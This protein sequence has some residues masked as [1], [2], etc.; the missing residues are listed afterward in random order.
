MFLMLEE[1][2]SGITEHWKLL[3][4]PLLVLIA[5]GRGGGIA[6]GIERLRLYLARG[7]S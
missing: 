1:V 2:L 6:G 4:G 7:T 3:F 5:L